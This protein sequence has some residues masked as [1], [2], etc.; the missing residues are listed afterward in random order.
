MEF[1]LK[2][3]KKFSEKYLEGFPIEAMPLNRDLAANLFPESAKQAFKR[4]QDL[5]ESVKEKKGIQIHVSHAALVGDFTAALMKKDKRSFPG[6]CAIT[7]VS[8]QEGQLEMLCEREKSH[9]LKLK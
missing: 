4:A 9:L 6:Y 2:G 1:D 7:G 5:L 8:M 3:P